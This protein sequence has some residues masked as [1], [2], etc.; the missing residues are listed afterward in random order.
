M[1]SRGRSATRLSAAGSR[2]CR[3]LGQRLPRNAKRLLRRHRPRLAAA[4]EVRAPLRQPMAV[5]IADSTC[6][7]FTTRNKSRV[8]TALIHDCGSAAL[9]CV[10]CCAEEQHSTKDE[11]RQLLP[12]AAALALGTELGVR[13]AQASVLRSQIRCC[14][15]CG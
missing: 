10:D 1:R 5:C 13:A 9:K 2:S 7:G 8:A 6:W 3:R 11:A 14:C 4:N 15:N 12:E